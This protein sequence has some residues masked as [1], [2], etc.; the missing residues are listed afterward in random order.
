[1]RLRQEQMAA[2]KAL[3]ELKRGKNP[4][5]EEDGDV[6]VD[7]ALEGQQM[8]LPAEHDT[9]VEGQQLRLGPS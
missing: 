5:T 3:K 9:Q 2:E 7:D 1:M 4:A 6:P 8:Q